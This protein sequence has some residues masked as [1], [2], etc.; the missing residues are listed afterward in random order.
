MPDYRAYEIGSDGHFTGSRAFVCGNDGDAIIW[1]KQL[2][3]DMPIELWS[4]AR[5][6]KHVPRGARNA[7]SYE[8][9][10]GR[11]AGAAGT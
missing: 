3:R 6:V 9:Q 10:Q 11:A 5:L 7:I 1:A 2:S 8:V 4:G